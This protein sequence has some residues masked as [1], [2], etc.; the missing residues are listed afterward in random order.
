MFGLTW[1]SWIKAMRLWS[2]HP[3][4]LDAKGLVALWR[5]GLLAVAVLKGK[6]HGYKNHPQLERFRNH[7][8]P[9]SA[10]TCYLHTVCDE[11]EKRGYRFQRAK[12]GRRCSPARMKV[13]NGQL[14]FEL[15]HLRKK[16]AERNRRAFTELRV[17]KFPKPHPLFR[18]VR[19]KIEVWEKDE[20]V[21]TG[22]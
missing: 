11:A 12:I 17:L 22:R 6:T 7:P 15:G 19:G 20:T 14:S 2:I 9:I 5:E 13:T 8:H 3:K 18:I 4:Y 1:K 21:R 16:L 10:I